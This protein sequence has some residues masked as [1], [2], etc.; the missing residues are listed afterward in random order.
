MN[1][2]LFFEINY[3]KLHIVHYVMVVY[4]YTFEWQI[5]KSYLTKW[6]FEQWKTYGT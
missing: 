1:K 4:C 6:P 3:G 2:F 5:N